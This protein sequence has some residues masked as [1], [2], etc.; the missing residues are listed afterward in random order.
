[1]AVE[2]DHRTGVVRGLCCKRCN[3]DL[4]GAAHDSLALLSAAW[5]YLN[6]PPASGNWPPIAE[7]AALVPNVKIPTNPEAM[8]IKPDESR[9]SVRSNEFTVPSAADKVT[10]SSVSNRVSSDSDEHEA[11]TRTHYLPAGAVSDPAGDGYFRVYVRN[12]VELPPPF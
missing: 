2:H 3:H 7:Q 5:H 8:G 10:P 11:C 1:M 12:V 6:T 4:L 9:G